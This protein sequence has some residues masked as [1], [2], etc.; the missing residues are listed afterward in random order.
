M[1]GAI[2]SGGWCRATQTVE[3]DPKQGYLNLKAGERVEVLHVGAE[4]ERGWLYGLSAERGTKGWLRL[5]NVQP[6]E[7]ASAENGR[8]GLPSST[9]AAI[10][11]AVVCRSWESWADQGAG[12]MSLVEG[13]RVEVLYVGTD[14]DE[15]GW[16]YGRRLAGGPV[17]EP[18]P[19]ATAA[20]QGRGAAA[21]GAS[22]DTGTGPP[23]AA[24]AATAAEGAQAPVAAAVAAAAAAPTTSRPSSDAASAPAAAPRF[25]PGEMLTIHRVHERMR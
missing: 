3:V 21:G 24:P 1:P 14:G 15:R 2:Q 16:V 8:G 12:Y 19:S 11:E 23:W 25:S 7:V 10:G 17:T 20:P 13:D 5:E 22:V 4:E 9:G 6:G 18:G